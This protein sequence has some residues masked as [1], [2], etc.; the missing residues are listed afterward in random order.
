MESNTICWFILGWRYQSVNFLSHNIIFMFSTA[1][2]RAISHPSC[3][4]V[5]TFI[6]AFF[7]A[8]TIGPKLS[9]IQLA[10]CC[11]PVDFSPQLMGALNNLATFQSISYIPWVI[12]GCVQ[13]AKGKKNSWIYLPY[14]FWLQLL[15]GYPQHVFYSVLLG[16]FSLLFI[17]TS[18]IK[19]TK[20]FSTQVVRWMLLGVISLLLTAYIWLPFLQNLQIDAE[21]TIS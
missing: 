15:G 13:F 3:S 5:F 9:K 19:L 17:G 7:L 8:K 1:G 4:F 11:S 2:K 6:G 21:L 10:S 20:V 12:F 14:L 18:K 16:F